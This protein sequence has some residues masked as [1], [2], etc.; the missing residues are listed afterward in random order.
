MRL[1]RTL[2]VLSALLVSASPVAAQWTHV[3]GLPSTDVFSVFT[4]GDT[5]VAGADTSVF[6]SLDSG[7]TWK[8]S[9]RVG[10]GVTEIHAV[11]YRN[12]RIYAGTLGQ[13]AFISDDLGS[14]W[15]GYSQGLVGGVFN[16]QLRV[17]DFLVRGDSLY[18]A[19]SG[20]GV[21]VRSLAVAGA[22]SPYGVLDGDNTADT[23]N[24][25]A[26]SDTRLLA[27]AGAN[28]DLFFRDRDA[29]VWRQSFLNNTS[30]LAGL[31]SQAAAWTGHGWVVGAN[32]G[33]FRS[34]QGQ[35]P[36]TK[37]GPPLGILFHVSFALR[38]RDVFA[39]LGIGGGSVIAFSGDDGVSWET[40]ETQNFVFIYKLAVSH[41]DLY[42]A[43]LDGLWRRPIAT[44]SAPSGGPSGRLQ[45]AVAG[46]QPVGDDVRFHFDLPEESAY[47]IEVFD[48][49][50]RRVAEPA[51]GVLT[52]GPHEIAWDARQLG[53][54]VHLVR[55]TAGNRRAV[56]RMIHVR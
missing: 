16:T 48:L 25:L 22:W 9:A 29:P 56:A 42:A 51:R 46:S 3:P 19:T 34:S 53:P 45:F 27:A 52:S 38:G 31:E 20:A 50:G 15:S 6:I 17:E 39:D 54:G 44:S 14:T 26:S 8:K 12:G 32:G 49:A 35:E 2:F 43:R 13:G 33:L 41:D 28:G 10:A 24:D 23:V 36:W 7:A 47:L 1:I 21:W 55:L 18:A 11:L 5:I 30:F 40:L 37:T 4:N